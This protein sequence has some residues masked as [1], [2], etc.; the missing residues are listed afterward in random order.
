MLTLQVFIEN[1][2]LELF[3]DESVTFTQV[4]QDVKSIDKIFTDFTRTFNVPASK[5]NNKIFEHFYDPHIVGFDARTKKDAELFLNFKT[6]QKGKVKLEGVTKKD[7]KPHTYKITFYGNTVKITDVIGDDKLSNLRYL[8][9]N[10]VFE[11]T[12]ANI[13][14]YMTSGLDITA[15][16]DTFPDAIIFPLISHTKRFVYDTTVNS[17]NV[18]T[19]TLNN[20]GYQASHTTATNYGLQLNQLKPALRIHAIIKA[21]EIQ[22][23]YTFS[24]D[25]FNITNQNYYNL[26]IWLHNKTGDLFDDENDVAFAKDFKADNKDFEGNIK[27]SNSTFDVDENERGLFIGDRDI[28]RELNVKVTPPSD[29]K[30]DLLIYKDGQLFQ[31]Y[32]GVSRTDGDGTNWNITEKKREGFLN[33][34][35]EGVYSIAIQSGSA[36]TY[37]IEGVVRVK[38]RLKRSED[39]F[40]GTA[41]VGSN[42]NINSTTQLPDMKV[43]DFLSGLFKMFN[44]TAVLN[45]SDII[46]VKTLDQFYAD[47]TTTWDITKDLDKDSQ[48]V[49]AVL[50]FNHITLGYSGLENF[51]AASHKE[52]F[53]KEWGTLEYN[54][55]RKFDGQSFKVELPFEHHKYERLIDINGNTVSPVQWGWSADVKQQPNLGKPLLFYAIP[56]AIDIAIINLDGT[57]SRHNANMYLPSNSVS[58]TD[59]FNINFA[60]EPNEYD[61]NGLSFEQTLFKTYYENYIKEI[62]EKSRRLTTTSAYLPLS[63]LMEFT[64]ADKIRIFDQLFKINKITTNF[65]TMKSVLELINIRETINT[66]TDS[67]AGTI[68]PNNVDLVVEPVV[69]DKFK[70]NVVCITAD[71]TAYFADNF[72]IRADRDCNF[73]GEEIKNIAEVIPIQMETGNNFITVDVVKGVEVTEAQIV[74]STSGFTSTSIVTLSA[75]VFKLGK[76]GQVGRW[77]EYGFFY[78]SNE[79]DLASRDFTTLKNTAGVTHVPIQSTALNQNVLPSVVYY[80]LEGLSANTTIYYV[81][82]IKTNDDANYDVN[83]IAYTKTGSRTTNST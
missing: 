56:T 44:L 18:N 77:S 8:Q 4:L 81:A 39:I 68:T 37:S 79:F 12:N 80:R 22:Y 45:D 32:D 46:E 20:L 35:T 36:G 40:T 53:Q 13:I 26:Y 23:G 74:L 31:R 29:D 63:M 41:T 54:I 6:F 1:Q 73:E 52:L 7:N 24:T 83:K 82:Y 78:C 60:S 43:I 2:Q 64:L 61:P 30:F 70:N 5:T 33:L 28:D 27:L 59:S 49:D 15:G 48:T 72:K 66:R 25:F 9:E 65:E 50:P 11:Y 62:F 38:R 47:S 16:T 75:N 17:T 21:I 76:I 69:L 58:Q 71:S 57:S 14:S 55:S 19:E 42:Q 3:K 51:F 67:Q 10:F 34:G